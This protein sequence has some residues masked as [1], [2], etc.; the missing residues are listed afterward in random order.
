MAGIVEGRIILDVSG[1]QPHEFNSL[2]FD[3]LRAVKP[4][5]IKLNLY[6]CAISV[7]NDNAH[8]FKNPYSCKSTERKIRGETFDYSQLDTITKRLAKA[9]VAPSERRVFDNDTASPR[10]HLNRYSNTD[11]RDIGRRVSSG[12]NQLELAVL[13]TLYTNR[14]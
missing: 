4:F 8:D 10:Y 1:T 2:I 12:A 7:R 9:T 13:L 6:S 5:K 11:W 14:M 3:S